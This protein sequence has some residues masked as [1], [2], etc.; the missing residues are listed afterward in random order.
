[1]VDKT[2][3]P[4]EP[5]TSAKHELLRL[6]LEAWFPILTSQ[7][8][9]RRVL[10]LDGFAGPGRY[11]GGE[12]G[13]PLIALDT[14]VNHRS[15]PKLSET[16]FVFIFVEADRDRFRS[17]QQ[18]V[19]QLWSQRHD[20]KL[21]NVQIDL[22]NNKFG[23]VATQIV[24]G[25]RE[26]NL[27]LAPTLAFI[28]PFGWSGVP[29]PLIGELLSSKKCEVIFNFMYD[30]VNRFVTDDRP[31][32]A[33]HFA[34]LFGTTADEHQQ[35]AALDGEERKEFL[36]ELYMHQLREVGRFRFVRSFE[37]KNVERGRTAYFLVFGTR[38]SKGLE[39]MKEAMWKVDPLS[40]NCF[41]GRA[42]EQ[43]ALFSPEPDFGPLRNALVEQFSGRTV[44]VAT[45]EKFVIE[46]TDYK[47]SHY[48][49]QVLKVLENQGRLV[50]ESDRDRRGTY[51]AHTRLRFLST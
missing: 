37:V 33:Q 42:G 16:E 32:I 47:K 38:H 31:G 40:G 44:T 51:P 23:S 15:F 18:E 41:T 35:A 14:L 2:I 39:V 24:D 49:K 10:F 48:K 6:Y 36:R 46:E 30:S 28:D 7:G 20:G 5:H 4:I 12:P 50:C 17:L 22:Y 43:L 3:W 26:Q 45:I 34:E 9:I 19:E 25:L 21:S 27:R 29:L 1:M 11:S 8:H 13:S